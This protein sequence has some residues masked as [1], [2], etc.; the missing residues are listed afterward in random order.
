MDN[1]R[2]QEIY[3]EQGRPGAEAFRFAARRAGIQIS[4]AEAKEFVQ[5]QSIGQVFQGR[6]PSDGVIPGGGREDHRWQM[7]LIDFSKRISKLNQN[8]K[9]V[10]IAVDIYNREIWT[11]PMQ[12]KTA[13]AT[14]EAFRKI[15][16]QNDNT[17]PKQITID[18]GN[19]YALLENEITTRG[20]VLT[21]K[22][23]SAVNTLAV[24][25]RVIGN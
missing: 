3:D 20:G 2:L 18:L 9:Y 23:M 11:Q 24:V 7:D 4:A 1:P 8:H 19:E 5:S 14:L 13:Q 16:R 21:R 25:D 6:I 10:L 12:N 22:N 15:I 17:M